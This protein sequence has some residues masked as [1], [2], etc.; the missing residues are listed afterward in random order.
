MSYGPSLP[1]FAGSCTALVTPFKNGAV[2]ADNFCKLVDFRIDNGTVA[3]VP[4][5]TT[6]ESPT[7]P[8]KSMI[9]LS[10]CIKQRLDACLS[11]PV[12]FKQH[13]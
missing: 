13:C 8:G 2:D 12:L 10:N 5:G 7:L 4:V 11:L 3:L 6:G 1:H 9:L